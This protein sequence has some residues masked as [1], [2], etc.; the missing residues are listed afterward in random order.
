V[1]VGTVTVGAIQNITVNQTRDLERV[2]EIGLDGVL[3]IVPRAPTQYEA[4]ITRIVFDRLRLP[5]SFARAFINIKSQLLPFDIEIIDRTNGDG[6]G[7][8]VHRL[9]KCW[10]N[11]YSP[12]YQADNFIIQEEATLW[13]ED[14]SSNLGNTQTSAVTG[15]ARGIPYAKDSLNREQQT[16][17]GAGGEGDGGGFR[18]TMDVSGIITASVL[19]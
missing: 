1:K 11:R 18:G 14:I 3:E 13:I 12:R 2:K 6:E 8:V 5:E 19:D 15:G 7:A 10:F 17:S 4:T 9:S 16:D